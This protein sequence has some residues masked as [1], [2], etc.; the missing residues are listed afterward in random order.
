VPEP[1]FE[2]VIVASAVLAQAREEFPPER[3]DDGRPSFRDFCEGPLEAAKLLFSRRFDTAP[4]PEPGIASIR[5]WDTMSK[6]FGPVV[7]YAMRVESHIEIISY[8]RQ[9]D[10]WDQVG[11]DSVD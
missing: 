6:I 10:Y 4:N 1:R 7:F 2:Q 8:L 9:G 3:T 11:D 5:Q